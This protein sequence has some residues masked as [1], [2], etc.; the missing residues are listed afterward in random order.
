M[1]YDY[2]KEKGENFIDYDANPDFWGGYGVELEV[3]NGGEK[4]TESEQ[5]VKLLDEEVYTMHDGSIFREADYEDGDAYECGGFE[6]ITYPHTEKALLNMKWERTFKHLLRH[7]YR[8]H[9]IKSCGLHMHISR[10]LFKDDDAIMKMMCFYEMNYEDVCNFARRRKQDAT[11]WANTYNSL[12]W[13]SGADAEKIC[14]S[15]FNTFSRYNKCGYHDMRYRC[16]NITKNNT[17]E[18]RIMRGTLNLATFYATLDF[19]IKIAKKANE[20]SWDEVL[21]NNIDKWFEDFDDST[22]E[23]MKSRGCFNQPKQYAFP[24]NPEAK[25]ANELRQYE[26]SDCAQASEQA[27]ERINELGRSASISAEQIQQMS[28]TLI[29]QGFAGLNSES[30]RTFLE[31]WDSRQDA[32]IIEDVGSSEYPF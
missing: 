5:V 3:G 20:I 11:R 15:I 26:V 13:L 32:I 2:D 27:R 28:D 1:Y 23:Y 8:S 14:T 17:V 10:T 16:V 25:E 7:N 31:R 6:I 12:D 19:L 21:E 4:D 9:D 30:L 29:N 24:T 18:V 22:F